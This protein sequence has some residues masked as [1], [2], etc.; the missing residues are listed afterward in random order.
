MQG[1]TLIVQH[2]AGVVQHPP[3]CSRFR[4]LN[5]RD[6]YT[7]RKKNCRQTERFADIA[8]GPENPIW[9]PEP[10]YS[11]TNFFSM[12]DNSKILFPSIGFPYPGSSQKQF[13]L[14]WGGPNGSLG[15]FWL[16]LGQK[17]LF[18]SNCP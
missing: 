3:H 1:W 2:L 15:A 11:H 17:V 4:V 14:S 13:L 12:G 9:P 5:C 7:E 10:W 16:I 18:L 6:Q 8:P